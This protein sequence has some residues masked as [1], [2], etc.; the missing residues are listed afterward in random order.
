MKVSL[1]VTATKGLIVGARNFPG[2]PYDGDTLAEQLEQVT[3]FTNRPVKTAIV[4]LGFRGRTIEDV[5][6]LH[7]GK[8]QCLTRSL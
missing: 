4:D 5:D 6:I 3:I 2:N 1:A 7:R 8:P